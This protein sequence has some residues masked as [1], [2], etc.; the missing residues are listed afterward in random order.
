MRKS[1]SNTFKDNF[2]ELLSLVSDAIMVINPEGVVLTVNKTAIALL[3]LASEELIG[4]HIE[5]LKIID[6]KTKAFVKNQIQKRIKGEKIETYEIP[7]IV[8]GATRY[9]EPDGNRI[10]YFGEP[11]DLIILRDVTEKREIQDKLLVKIAQMDEQCQES[12]GK[13]R[14]LF[15]ESTDAL[16]IAD[17]ETCTII[18]CNNAATLLVAMDREELIGKKYSDLRS[19]MLLER[20]SKELK[21]RAK[22]G[23]TDPLEAKIITKSGEKKYVSIRVSF[24]EFQGKKFVQGTFRDITEHRL[25]RQALT[26]NEEKFHGIANSVSDAMIAVDEKGKVTYW[27]PP[28]E[29]TFGYTSEE[30][31]G[32]DIHKIV[33]PKTICKEGKER[34]KSSVKIFTETG[35]G[36]FTFGNV[37]LIGRRKDGSDFPVELSISPI[38]LCGK[39]NAVGVI[40]DITERKNAGQK[41]RDA[42]QRY[43]ALFN[44]APLG[45]LVIDPEKEEFL[46]FNDTAYLQ[47]GYSKE[48]FRKLTI[49]DIDAKESAEEMSLH[50]GEMVKQGGGEFET[51]HRTKNGNIRNVLVTT[52]IIELMGK[53]LLYGIFHDITEIRKVQD[54]LVES[55]ARY[56]QLVELAHEGIWAFSKDFTTVFVNPRMAKMLGYTESEMV[57]KS[58]FQFI[59]SSVTEKARNVLAQTNMNIGGQ[60]E[61]AFP[62]K[63]GT[64][65]NTSITASKITDDQGQVIGTLALLSDIT[66]RKQLE[67]E[68]RTSEE[69]FRAISSSAL[70]AIILVDEEDKI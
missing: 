11:V 68:L 39:W 30:T 29:K 50:I 35:A 12:E 32:K 37:E 51:L 66:E 10:D 48:E 26:E 15:Q 7:V 65:I 25:M 69:R 8:N 27:N 4:K 58:L 3:G 59:E 70:D 52:R 6:E 17:A 46:E 22:G 18:D 21:E 42:E 40:K 9:F 13:Y 64:Y 43:H 19:Q 5:D 38:K 24:F 20:D 67:N 23:T 41:L 53:T 2:Q 63:D 61:Y 36:Y 14:K 28:A 1:K 49:H 57:G 56:R 47:L 54:A 60:F 33:V 34:I 31:I 16:F 44:E 55:E 45:V 62:R